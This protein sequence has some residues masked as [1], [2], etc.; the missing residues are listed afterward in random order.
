MGGCD[1]R[2]SCF[3]YNELL[4]DMPHTTEHL[5]D[6]YCNGDYAHCARFVISRRY[7]MDNVPTYIYPNDDFAIRM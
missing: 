2:A 1:L 5:R 7:G 6:R 3:F 4:K